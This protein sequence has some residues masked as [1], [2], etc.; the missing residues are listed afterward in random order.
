MTFTGEFGDDIP[1]LETI[2][3]GYRQSFRIGSVLVSCVP[4]GILGKMRLSNANFFVY[5][6]KIPRAYTFLSS[7]LL[8]DLSYPDKSNDDNRYDNESR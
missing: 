7:W 6:P 8:F 5:P 1:L 2:P 4:N 3:E